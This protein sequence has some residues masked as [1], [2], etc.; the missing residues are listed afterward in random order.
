MQGVHGPRG[1]ALRRLLHSIPSQVYNGMVSTSRPAAEDLH[2][3]TRGGLVTYCFQCI[4]VYVEHAGGAGIALWPPLC[5]VV[6]PCT[7]LNLNA[8]QMSSHA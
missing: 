2:F 7:S 3:S 6:P 4:L 5:V 1:G 8:T